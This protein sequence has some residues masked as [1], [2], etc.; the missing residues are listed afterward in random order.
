MRSEY[1]K[2]FFYEIKRGEDSNNLEAITNEMAGQYL[3]SFD[4]KTP[5]ATHR[6]YQ[7][8]EDKHADLFG[9]PIVTAH[10]IVLCHVI[11]S[12]IVAIQPLITNTLFAR[13][14]LTRYFILFTIKLI[15][16]SDQTARDV[17]I[18]PEKYVLDETARSKFR[19]TIALL[20]AEVV[21][22]LNAEIDQLGTDFDYR[23]KLRDEKW[24]KQLA[25]EIAATHKKLVD[26]GRLETFIDIFNT[27]APK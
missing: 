21:T 17:L 4:L 10:R 3:M 26:R 15:L 5:W 16:D 18:F 22:D 20:L 27:V 6:K 7:I 13:Y 12:E 24:C 25:H 2:Y 8:F 19:A 1:G 23:G 11:T 14:V 9:R